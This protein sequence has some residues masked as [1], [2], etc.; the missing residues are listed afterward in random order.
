VLEFAGTPDGEE[1]RT[2][3]RF[4]WDKTDGTTTVRL[5]HSGFATDAARERDQGWPWLLSLLRPYAENTTTG[6]NA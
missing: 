3:V 4:E 2:V 6:S 1:P 5:M